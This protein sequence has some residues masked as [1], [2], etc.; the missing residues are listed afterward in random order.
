[1][2]EDKLIQKLKS[3]KI[4]ITEDTIL[5]RLLDHLRW[6]KRYAFYNQPS[7]EAIME[8][9][10]IH[11]NFFDENFCGQKWIFCQFFWLLHGGHTP[12]GL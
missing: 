11:Q 1:M 9:G 8:D 7:V 3:Q 6:P 2:V 10:S 4:D 5:E 12:M